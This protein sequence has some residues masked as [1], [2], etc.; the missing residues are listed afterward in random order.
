MQGDFDYDYDYD[1]GAV[2]QLLTVSS[3]LYTHARQIILRRLPYTVDVEDACNLICFIQNSIQAAPRAMNAA[4]KGGLWHAVALAKVAVC[5]PN[6]RQL[7]LTLYECMFQP[8]FHSFWLPFRKIQVLRC[9]FAGLTTHEQ[10]NVAG[11]MLRFPFI[12]QLSFSWKYERTH[13]DNGSESSSSTSL[14]TDVQYVL[15][16]YPGTDS[17][18]LPHLRRIQVDSTRY[19]QALRSLLDVMD[20]H[21]PVTDLKLSCGLI[22][23]CARS[24][25]K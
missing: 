22:P 1:Y 12:E 7:E 19:L 8:T 25:R 9:G 21:P 10:A 23:R 16:K 14:D 24:L 4:C 13:I 20:H 17:I 2:R 15:P 6:L 18:Q 11:I 3:V 5:C